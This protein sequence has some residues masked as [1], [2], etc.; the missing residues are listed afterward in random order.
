MRRKVTAVLVSFLV[1]SA[2]F[3]TDSK[4]LEETKKTKQEVMTPEEKFDAKNED[5]NNEDYYEAKELAIRGNA[6]GWALAGSYILDLDY[7]VSDK[8]T[9]GFTGGLYLSLIHI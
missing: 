7:K 6:I 1:S 3:A 8:M 5:A 4:P 9:V 2:L